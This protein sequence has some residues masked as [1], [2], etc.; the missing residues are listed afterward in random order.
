MMP[1]ISSVTSFFFGH[2]LI[3]CF[4]RASLIY[5]YIEYHDTIIYSTSVSSTWAGLFLKLDNLTS[6]N[7]LWESGKSLTPTRI[8]TAAFK[9]Y[10][11]SSFFC[12][13]LV[14]KR[15]C[16]ELIMLIAAKG[17]FRESLTEGHRVIKPAYFR[18]IEF[19]CMHNL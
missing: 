12:R 17:F 11:L 8:H 19:L 14:M 1:L 2:R 18:F 5:M 9:V 15:E 6:K 16:E 3:F 7:V 10:K 4:M 13:K